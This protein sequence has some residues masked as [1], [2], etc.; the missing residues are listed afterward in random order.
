MFNKDEKDKE[1]NIVFSSTVSRHYIWVTLLS[2][3]GF[4]VVELASDSKDLSRSKK[5]SN[6]VCFYACLRFP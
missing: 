2:I 6:M 3:F 4:L 1:S 5:L